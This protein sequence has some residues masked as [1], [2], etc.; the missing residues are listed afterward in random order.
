[1]GVIQNEMNI[2]NEINVNEV[3][4]GNDQKINHNNG[5]GMSLRNVECS[6]I[7]NGDGCIN[8]NNLPLFE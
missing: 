6:D 5:L 3:C 7:Y 1:M 4:R 8:N 2:K